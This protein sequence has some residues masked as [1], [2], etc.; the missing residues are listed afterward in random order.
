VSN[1][2]YGQLVKTMYITLAPWLTGLVIFTAIIAW[3]KRW[4]NRL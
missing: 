1:D 2:F 4:I 3:I